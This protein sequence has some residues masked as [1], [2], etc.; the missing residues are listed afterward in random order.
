LKDQDA[1][2]YWNGGT[3]GG[4]G[5]WDST[6]PGRYAHWQTATGAGTWNLTLPP[7][8]T[9]DSRR[10]SVWVRSFDFAG[11]VSTYPTTAQLDANLNADGTTPAY[12]FTYDATPP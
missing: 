1:Q 2:A 10:L 11:N 3:S 7:L 12:T 9:V 6:P 4:A 5:D 8:A